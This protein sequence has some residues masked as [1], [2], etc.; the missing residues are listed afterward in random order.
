VYAGEPLPKD[1]FKQKSKC[2]GTVEDHRNIALDV[3]ELIRYRVFD[4]PVGSIFR[5]NIRFP[6]LRMM[7]LNSCSLDLEL[8]TGRTVIVPLVWARC[9][10]MGERMRIECPL[11]TRRVCALYFLDGRIACRHCNGLWYGAQRTSAKGRKFQ[12]MRNVRRKLGDYG[13]FW[14]AK[15][16]QS[17][18]ACGGGPMLGIVRRWPGSSGGYSF[19]HCIRPL[20]KSPAE[21]IGAWW[22][23]D[24]LGPVES[25]SRGLRMRAVEAE[26]GLQHRSRH[27]APPSGR[28][29][30]AT[31]A[32]TW[33]ANDG[34]GERTFSFMRR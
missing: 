28:S 33:T 29:I 20:P 24:L 7:R 6:W 2:G 32:T 15:S 10:I 19:S 25:T 27:F 16:R 8:V 34:F 17:R 1:W 9:G 4:Q 21:L 12:A 30:L 26:T 11:C 13:Q 18:A 3:R 22:L 14:A 31:A 23:V 5:L